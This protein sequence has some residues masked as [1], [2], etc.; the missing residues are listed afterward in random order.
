MVVDVVEH[1]DLFLAIVKGRVLDD[2]GDGLVA[3]V[4][5]VDPGLLL[6]LL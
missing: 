3:F 5:V 1:L 6:L 2:G 4:E